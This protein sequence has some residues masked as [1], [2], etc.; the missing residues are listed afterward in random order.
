MHA[1]ANGDFPP[2]MQYKIGHQTFD[3]PYYL[4]DGIYPNWP[5]FM[6]PITEPA[7]D[8]E[9]KYTKLQEALRKDVE[10]A[11]GVLK[12]RF[13][14]LENPSKLWSIARVK[15]MVLT[16]IVIH[17]LI[18]SMQ[19]ADIF[20]DEYMDEDAERDSH[21]AESENALQSNRHCDEEAYMRLRTELIKNVSHHMSR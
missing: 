21:E 10:R 4:A 7:T 5:I 9:K 8:A 14:C 16:C 6:K 15:N 18:I 1:I 11:Y 20:F 17:N 13:Q 3:L 12:I 2:E 19:C